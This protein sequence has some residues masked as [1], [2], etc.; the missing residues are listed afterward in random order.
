MEIVAD[1]FVVTERGDT[2]GFAAD[3]ADSVAGVDVV[4]AE[5]AVA[6][7]DEEYCNLACI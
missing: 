3:M 6:A 4:A 2:V 7:D 1:S 5:N